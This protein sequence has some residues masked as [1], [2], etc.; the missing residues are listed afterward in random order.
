L[1]KRATEAEAEAYLEQ[2]R[3]KRRRHRAHLGGRRICT[4]CQHLSFQYND[5]RKS[6]T[7]SSNLIMTKLCKKEQQD[8]HNVMLAL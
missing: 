5:A 8:G 3:Q 7:Q 6:V 4:A 1:V 2:L